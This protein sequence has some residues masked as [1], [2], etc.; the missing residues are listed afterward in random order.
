MV[1]VRPP[2]VEGG[3]V[4]VDPDE[5]GEVVAVGAVTEV[6]V[7]ETGFDVSGTALVVEFGAGAVVV[8]RRERVTGT[9]G[10]GTAGT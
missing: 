7:V 3:A 6:D 10:A 2:P 9:V 5:V 1:V 4:D 8:G